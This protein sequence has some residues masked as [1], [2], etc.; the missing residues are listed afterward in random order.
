MQLEGIFL[1]AKECVSKSGERV[2]VFSTFVL[3][4]QGKFNQLQC[5]QLPDQRLFSVQ[6]SKQCH[7]FIGQCEIKQHEVLTDMFR[8]CVSGYDCPILRGKEAEQNLQD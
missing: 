5:F 7:F 6:G 1:E 4:C 2:M 3:P 8:I